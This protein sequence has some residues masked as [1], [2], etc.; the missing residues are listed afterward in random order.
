MLDGLAALGWSRAMH[1][2]T[3]VAAESALLPSRVQ[4]ALPSLALLV[5]FDQRGA[6]ESPEP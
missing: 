3:L 6:L 4:M 2:A 1:L 5:Y